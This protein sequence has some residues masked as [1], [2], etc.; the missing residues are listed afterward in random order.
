[1]A[2][3]SPDAPEFYQRTH[4]VRLKNSGTSDKKSSHKIKYKK[5]P[6]V[7]VN[8]Y[9]T[10]IMQLYDVSVKSK[11]CHSLMYQDCSIAMQFSQSSN[12]SNTSNSRKKACS[13]H[14]IPFSVF[15][16]SISINCL[17][18]RAQTQFILLTLTSYN[19]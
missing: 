12:T 4:R 2:D 14:F 1:M 15:G 11:F 9:N 10:I 7:H 6:R 19:I 8:C 5:I 13:H 18:V 3:F 17:F 16:V